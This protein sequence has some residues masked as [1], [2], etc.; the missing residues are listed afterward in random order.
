MPAADT[1]K[2]RQ[3]QAE[4]QEAPQQV[5][6]DPVAMAMQSMV[7]FEDRRFLVQQVAVGKKDANGMRELTFP[8]APAKQITLILA[9]ELCEHIVKEFTGGLQIADLNDL[10]AVKAAAAEAEEKS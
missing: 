4:E 10:E 8:I 9:E 2:S 7:A 1:E 3:D 6:V 5:Q